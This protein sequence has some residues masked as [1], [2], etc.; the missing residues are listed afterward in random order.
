MMTDSKDINNCQK[1]PK[2][3]K[4]ARLFCQKLFDLKKIED[5]TVTDRNFDQED[6]PQRPMSNLLLV[7]D[8][9]GAFIDKTKK[10]GVINSFWSWNA[11]F[12]DVDNDEWQ[13]LY[14][15]NGFLLNDEMSTNVFFNNQKGQ[16]F[17][18]KEK[19]FGLEDFIHTHSYTYIDYDLDGDLDILATGNYAPLRLFKNHSKKGHSLSFSFVYHKGNRNGIG[20]KVI[21]HYGNQGE[22]RQIREVKMGGGFLSFDRPWVH[23]GLGGN[24]KVTKVEVIWSTGE[25]TTLKK[26]FRVGKHYQIE[27]KEGNL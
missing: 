5:Q 10:F 8:G 7:S 26:D 3:L 11:K 4:E 24:K 17:L 18:Q 16:S 20:N 9:K 12:A 21:I 15:G 19:E 1:I 22:S 23:F 14:V 25:K 2:S 6:L 13:D 27:R